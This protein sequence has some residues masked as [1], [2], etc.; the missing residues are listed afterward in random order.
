LTITAELQK[1][2]VSFSIY[3]WPKKNVNET[4]VFSVFEANL[5]CYPVLAFFKSLVFKFG[6]ESC[7]PSKTVYSSLIKQNNIAIAPELR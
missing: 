6:L 3:I 1:K 2:I 4:K 5:S 7:H